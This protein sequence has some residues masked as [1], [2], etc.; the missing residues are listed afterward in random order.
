M[1]YEVPMKI[2]R[3]WLSPLFLLIVVSVLFVQDRKLSAEQPVTHKDE[4]NQSA[5]SARQKALDRQRRVIFND[6]TYELSREDANTPT[7]FL[8][9]RL[10]PL[11]G[12]HVDT[13]A[14]S[15]LGGWADA[16]VYDSK[17]QPIYGDAHGSPP[18]YWRA[19]TNNVKELIAAGRC[20]L[21]IVIDFAHE[22]GMELFASVRMNDCHDSFIAGGVTLWKKEH[23][24]L[25][26]DRGDVPHN[27]EHPLG[28]YAITQDFS[29][30]EVR[31]RKFEIIEEVCQRYDIDG[32][33][34]N[35]I[36]HP[37]FF[38]RTMRGLPVT[39]EETQIMTAFMGR[40]RRLTDTEGVRRGRPILVSAIV[41][42]NFQLAKNV[43]LDVKKWIVDD[44]ID[45]VT[46]GLGY[47]PFAL[48][49]KE[50][51]ELAQQHGVKVYPCINCRAPRG[52]SESAL[53]EGSRG[54]ATNWYHDGSDGL[55]FWNLGTP[56]EYKQG[57]DLLATR[58]RYYAA[59]P[60]LGDPEVMKYK[61]KLFCVDDPVFKYYQHISSTPA[62]PV[63]VKSEKATAVSFMVGDNVK[64]ADDK[65][66]LK[67][68]KLVLTFT[69]QVEESSLALHFNGHL[70]QD[71]RVT[72]DGARQIEYRPAPQRINQ[73]RNRLQAMLVS[74][75]DDPMPVTLSG[76]HLWVDYSE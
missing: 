32:V 29:H 66:R 34:L 70:L 11:V 42:D 19:V 33:Y 14:W 31:D 2:A 4:E 22:N 36:R 37:V 41:P 54:V 44:L 47:A 7:G 12:T 20:P 38:S 52:V 76:L 30:Q 35:Y 63:E 55:F 9:R 64:A 28:L 69:Q 1:G 45:M 51:T 40:I 23:P 75:T 57:K 10:K 6:D 16:P 26:V 65:G 18:E 8:R 49:V 39:D 15:I 46:P 56:F 21:Q 48:P 50:F 74:T 60:E 13:I 17:V 3:K 27:M 62:L 58:S 24:E 25:L 59:L 68:L 67:G 53:K 72:G 5:K 71:G 73:G 43:G 61:D